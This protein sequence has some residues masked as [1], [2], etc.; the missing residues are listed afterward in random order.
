MAIWVSRSNQA[1]PDLAVLLRET[2]AEGA[3]APTAAQIVARAGTCVRRAVNRSV[4]LYR[5]TVLVPEGLADR[6]RPATGL[7]ETGDLAFAYELVV[8]E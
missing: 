6:R 8:P 5:G 1:N 3:P 7:H 4:A 2:S